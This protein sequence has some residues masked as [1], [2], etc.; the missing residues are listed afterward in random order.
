[1]ARL[2]DRILIAGIGGA[3]LGTEVAKCLRLAGR[4]DV[5]G[6]DISP[7]A[8]GHYDPN[9]VATEVVQLDRYIDGVIDTCRK[10]DALVVVPGAEGSA[11]LLSRAT[12]R[13]AGAGIAFASNSPEIVATCSHKG[14]FFDTLAA[15][16][17]AI[18]WTI[19]VTSLDEVPEVPGFP[20]IVKPATGTGGS[21]FVSLAPDR[22]ALLEQVVMALPRAG[23]LVVQEYIPSDEG[24][25]TVGVLRFPDA[26]YC[27]SLAIRRLFDSKLSVLELS[28]DGLLS[29]GYSQGLVDT[30]PRVRE[31]AEAI[32][33][34]LDADGPINIQG[35]VRD[36][37][38]LPFEANP[39]FS[40]SVFLRALAGFNEPDI[41]LRHRLHGE[42]PPGPD[43]RGGYYLRSLCETFV[44]REAAKR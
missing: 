15:S 40:A 19:R 32:A 23:E 13:L 14:R 37:Q 43:I 38:F 3:S 44:P 41:Y 7:L 28:G 36:G 2:N 34:S 9:F 16:G 17:V 4:Y 22:Q 24:E 18:P 42:V 26:R 5:F 33:E 11:S 27:E 39:R 29:S 8:F 12:D 25:Y 10:H 21:R 1:M 30:F 20:C 6:C 35:R 31:Q